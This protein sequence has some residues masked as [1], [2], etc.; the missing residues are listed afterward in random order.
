MEVK[1]SVKGAIMT[2]K[3]K[4]KKEFTD[5]QIC[6]F[7]YSLVLLMMIVLGCPLGISYIMDE[8]GTVANAAYLAGYNWNDWVN[9]TGGYF[10][11]YGQAVFYYPIL[12]WVSN[13]YLIYKFMM[14][15]NGIVL[16]WVPV[17]S[18]LILR[19]HLNQQDK[20]KCALC[21]LCISVIPAT[22]LYS[23]Y[24]RA[25]VILCSFALIIIYTILEC[26]EAVGIKKQIVLS[27]LIAFFSVYTYMCQARGIVFVIATFM[28]VFLIRFI[29]KNKNVLF[30]A[31]F[32]SLC[33]WMF[34][35]RR[36]TT[37]FKSSI[38]GSGAKKNTFSSV[39]ASKYANLL[40]AK[41][42]ETVV[43]NVSGWLFSSFLG[44]YGL[45]I[46]GIFFALVGIVCY[47]TKKKNITG[48]ELVFQ[49]YAVLIY[50]GTLALG[51]LFSFGSNYKFVIGENIKR[52]DRFLY[53]RYVAPAYGVLVLVA[54]FYL[55]FKTDCFKLK[56]KLA[57]L[58]FG[59]VL[60]VYCRGWLGHFVNK[61]EYSWRNTIDAA[62]FFD[63]VRYG[64]D[65]NKY[66]NVSR[67]L[68][69]MG[70]LAFVVLFILIV[71]NGNYVTFKKKK[72]VFALVGGCF[73]VS[74]SVNYVKLRLSTDVRPM[75]TVG[76]AITEM[77]KLEKETNI[78][79]TYNEVYI[80]KSIS[81]YKMMQLAMPKYTVHV[82]KS[83]SPSEVENMFI[84]AANYSLKEE[85]MGDDCY[86]LKGY[87]LVNTRSTII[88]K[89]EEL[90]N[91]LEKRGIE[92]EPIPSDYTE[93]KVKSQFRPFMQAVK[94]SLQYQ[95][96]TLQ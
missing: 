34:V 68:L 15:A 23:L 88:V 16:A 57:A 73:L 77:C 35:D 92:L 59:G 44:T 24:A 76:S 83:I 9:S 53:S 85:W 49:V 40:T 29:L 96:E 22:V 13:P 58:G 46:L 38:W 65:A 2:D 95:L 36:L 93:G 47:F 56:T 1:F 75:I 10:Y 33:F 37:Y 4:E 94:E 89:G 82:R 25:E 81:R 32:V 28:V 78:S 31:Y 17:M 87:D 80:D 62:L 90:K 61:V 69:L 20:G 63:T 30:S 43:K 51:V 6:V 71:L 60:L 18:Y 50:F 86:L 41:G 21:S 54:L 8:T 12:K 66:S 11:K 52:A 7:M 48:K 39:H 79:D 70:V 84:I 45:V 72:F 64:N 74:L 67:A 5:L 14:F 26:M 91:E 27:A 3:I 19:K 55:F 42:I